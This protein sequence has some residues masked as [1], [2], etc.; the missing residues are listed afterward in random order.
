M[1]PIKPFSN[2]PA[3]DCAVFRNP[4]RNVSKAFDLS[5]VFHQHEKFDALLIATADF[6]HE[7]AFIVYNAVVHFLQVLFPVNRP[8]WFSFNLLVHFIK[9]LHLERDTMP[10]KIRFYVVVLFLSC[11]KNVHICHSS[12]HIPLFGRIFG[13]SSFL[14]L[15]NGQEIYLFTD[16]K[17]RMVFYFVNAKIVIYFF[18][19]FPPFFTFN[20]YSIEQFKI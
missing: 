9:F 15:D 1:Q 10:F 8:A 6:F 12:H 18:K 3:A 13:G 20:I 5:A 14:Y 11:V 17:Q 16:C 4:L 7:S 2:L 19:L